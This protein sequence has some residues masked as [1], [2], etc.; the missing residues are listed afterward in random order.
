MGCSMQMKIQKGVNHENAQGHFKI[1][2][3]NAR[4]FCT[5]VD[6]KKIIYVWCEKI[7]EGQENYYYQKIQFSVLRRK[8][9]KVLVY[10]IYGIEFPI[11]NLLN[12]FFYSKIA[13]DLIAKRNNSII[14][15]I[16]VIHSTNRNMQRKF[17]Y[18]IIQSFMNG[19]RKNVSCAENA[20]K[21]TSNYVHIHFDVV[22]ITFS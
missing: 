11:K 21:S 5:E 19:N 7:K 22:I 18:Q 6:F 4:Q 16:F 2:I 17:Q 8:Y 20:V 15:S 14:L 3:V 9:V 10:N 12:N 1:N 13:F